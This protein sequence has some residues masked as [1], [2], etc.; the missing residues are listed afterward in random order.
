MAERLRTRAQDAEKRRAVIGESFESWRVI[1]GD[2]SGAPDASDS[3]SSEEAIKVEWNE[4]YQ[5][6]V[7]HG[8][9]LEALETELVELRIE[10][11]RTRLYTNHITANF[12]SQKYPHADVEASTPDHMN[13]T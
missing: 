13:L 12:K 4:A 5:Q 3:F 8:K 6:A 7:K 1:H 2:A 10:K 11:Q 9:A